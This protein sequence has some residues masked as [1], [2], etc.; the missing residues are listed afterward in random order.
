[1]WFWKIKD[2]VLQMQGDSNK[3]EDVYDFFYGD[4]PENPPT[5]GIFKKEARREKIYQ[6]APFEVNNFN[7]TR[8]QKNV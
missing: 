3:L 8:Q 7:F 6:L 2:F 4:G 5:S 1:M